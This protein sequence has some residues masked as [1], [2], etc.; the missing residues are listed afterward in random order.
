[1]GGAA[2]GRT[3][4]FSNPV[5]RIDSSP[6]VGDTVKHTTCYMCACRCGIRVHLK[7][8]RIRYIEGNPD[9]PVNRGVLCAKGSA[10]IMQHYSPARLHQAAAARRAAR[11]GRLQGDRVGGSARHRRRLARQ[12][13]RDRSEEARLLHRA[14]PEPVLHRLVGQAVRHPQFRRPRRV[15]FGQH[16]RRRAVFDRRQL[17]GV[18]RPGLGPDQI[19]RDV[20]RRRGPRFQPDQGRARE[21]EGARGEVHLGQPGADRLFGDRR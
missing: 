11:L 7:D 18:R 13:P 21:A 3:T 20:R 15:L 17:L 16:G 5:E 9:H 10:G 2:S 8:G 6:P 19:L 4:G 1:M 12:H 14:R